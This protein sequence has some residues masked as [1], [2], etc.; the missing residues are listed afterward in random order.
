MNGVC[1]HHSSKCVCSMQGIAGVMCNLSAA[2][3]HA[4]HHG[5]LRASGADAGRVL[6]G[7]E[8]GQT[9]IS[10]LLYCPAGSTA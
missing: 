5:T 1:L 6:Q 10:S 3:E 8:L 7:S 9:P 4:V 2:R